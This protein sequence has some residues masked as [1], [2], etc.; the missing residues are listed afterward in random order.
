[1]C[2]ICSTPL[3]ELVPLTALGCSYCP[4]LTAIPDT[5]VNLT[6]LCCFRCP[7]LTAIPNAGYTMCAGCP[8][9]PRNADHF[10]RHAPAVARIQSWFRAG[11][12][13]TLKRYLR[14]RAFNEWFWAGDQ[15]GGRVHKR[16]MEWSMRRSV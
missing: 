16:H 8:W 2:I 5:L 15:P 6:R 10:P 1:M 9:L 7:L 13:Q 14:T 12:K 3:A 4:L 11:K